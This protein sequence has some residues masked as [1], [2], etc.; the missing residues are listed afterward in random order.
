ML[1][2]AI[3]LNNSPATWLGLADPSLQPLRKRACEDVAVAAGGLGDNDA[4][5]PRRIPLRPRDARACRRHGSARDQMQKL[6]SV[7]KF[8]GAL[9]AVC[10]LQPTTVA[11]V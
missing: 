8:H 5:R 10:R 3:I 1:T 4:H 7:R 11:Q 6:S 9:P 2:P